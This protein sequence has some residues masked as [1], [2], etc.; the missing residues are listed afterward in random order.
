MKLLYIGQFRSGNNGKKL[1]ERFAVLE[2]DDESIDREIAFGKSKNI[3]G[4][5]VGHIYAIDDPKGSTYDFSS[6]TWLRE[7]PD[8]A[9]VAR[10]QAEYQAERVQREALMRERR[11]AKNDST[12]ERLIDPLREA[13][14]NV[15]YAQRP[16]FEVWLLSRIRANK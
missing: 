9:L 15:P 12:L 1:V 5:R 6:T 8:E 4:Y 2:D 14:K 13:Y 10:L 11:E 16:A 7:H 3:V